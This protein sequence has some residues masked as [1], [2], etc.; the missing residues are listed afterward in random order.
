MEAIDK[1]NDEHVFIKLFVLTRNN[2][3][4]WDLGQFKNEIN[5]FTRLRFVNY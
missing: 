2:E 3:S 4:G 5:V 1:R